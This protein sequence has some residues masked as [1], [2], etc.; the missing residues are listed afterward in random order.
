MDMKQLRLRD[1]AI[2]LLGLWMVMSPRVLLFTGIQPEVI[3]NAWLVGA[4]IILAT[5]CSRFVI[6]MWSPWQDGT[7]AMLGLWLMISPWALGF[8]AHMTA[9]NNS[10]IVGF[11][12]TVL[13]LWAMVVDT[14]LR[15]WMGDWMHQHHLLR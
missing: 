6:E 15:K 11:L 7:N 4:A 1:W 12:V 9:R 10:V 8:A 2:A 13:A 14:D 5:V 3:W